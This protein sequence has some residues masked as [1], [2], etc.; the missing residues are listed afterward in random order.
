M[1]RSVGEFI[2]YSSPPNHR[3]QISSIFDSR[4][5]YNALFLRLGIFLRYFRCSSLKLFRIFVD[6]RHSTLSTSIRIRFAFVHVVGFGRNVPTIYFPIVLCVLC[7]GCVWLAPCNAADAAASVCCL[8]SCSSRSRMKRHR[9]H[10]IVAPDFTYILLYIRTEWMDAPF[11]MAH[12]ANGHSCGMLLFHFNFNHIVC[13]MA[14]LSTHQASS[15]LPIIHI[16]IAAE[17]FLLFLQYNSC[18]KMEQ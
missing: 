12:K 16:I 8:T 3:T 11:A 9:S 14:P 13:S 15:I 10:D 4:L 1:C 18:T 2:F 5:G 17:Q 7:E 6:S